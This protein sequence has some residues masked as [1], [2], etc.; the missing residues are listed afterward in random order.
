MKRQQSTSTLKKRK[1]S[2]SS[3]LKFLN[4]LAWLMQRSSKSC[5]A[6]GLINDKLLI[7][8]NDIYQGTEPDN[9]ALTFIRE[10][11]DYFSFFVANPNNKDKAAEISAKRKI[12]FQFIFDKKFSGEEKGYLKPATEYKEE[13]VKNLVIILEA[14]FDPKQTPNT[15]HH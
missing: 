2:S 9:E 5:T 15:K 11:M 12:I 6:V 4:R 13:I 8:D 7:A 3:P 10:I 14:T 1:K